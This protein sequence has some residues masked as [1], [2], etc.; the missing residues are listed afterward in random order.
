MRL[1]AM[2]YKVLPALS[3]RKAELRRSMRLVTAAWALGIVWNTCVRGSWIN[4]FQVMLGF[5]NIHFGLWT[6]I[7]PLAA[8]G[9]LIAV[10]LI[11]RTGMRKG[12]FIVT[13]AASRSLWLVVALILVTLGGT[14]AG[15]WLVL[16]TVL[17]IWVLD[18][19]GTP[20]WQT[21]MGDLL[22]RR[23]RGRYW[24]ARSRIT[25]LLVIPVAIGV[26]IF[27]DQ[28]TDPSK[29]MTV[30]DQPALLWSLA[31]A[32]AAAAL[33]G[34]GDV[35]V[36]LR[37]REVCPTVADRPRPPAVDFGGIPRGG[38]GPA[39]AA[40]RAARHARAV[41]S[42]LLLGPLGDRAFR[43]YVLY[44]AT[45]TFAMCVGGPFYIRNMKENLGLSH[46]AINVIYM[47]LGPLM[48]IL[49]AKPWG[50]LVDRWGRR[51]MLMAATAVASFGAVPYFFASRFTPNPPHVA[52]GVNAAAGLV[53][54]LGASAA[55]LLGVNVDWA[56]W[57][58]LAPGAPVGAWMI[59][60]T[61]IFFGFV[62]W[63]GV[64]IG[65]QGIILGF[66]DGPG[67]SKY[68]AAHA[69]LCGLGGFLG[70]NVGGLIAD[71][72][73]AA[74]WYH[75]LHV[76]P[77]EWNNWHATFLASTAARVTAL[78]LLIHMPDPGARRAR[79]MV[80]TVGAEMFQVLSGRLLTGWL[81][82]GRSRRSRGPKR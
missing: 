40:V 58:P 75:P 52:G 26:S 79:D 72:L 37:I 55:S 6:S 11:D 69:A 27:M 71:S 63:S 9:N 68:V 45:V 36:F 12:L 1:R 65:Q 53:G 23:I 48:A 80:R 61:T 35:L 28:M 13:K 21:W 66:A 5:T 29:P 82:F 8:L 56:S 57:Q 42:Q 74:P 70:A 4:S 10:V 78:L 38:A 18:S 77:F 24:A 64:M 20:A 51:P 3:V 15:I 60:A 39:A 16:L 17:A 73:A 46:M 30:A 32:L 34:V 33:F 50:R 14:P 67:R 31:G 59:C 2:S 7:P 76:G 81:G 41:V 44:G 62:G 54:S 19:L 43:R 49:A 47:I 22:P 25:R